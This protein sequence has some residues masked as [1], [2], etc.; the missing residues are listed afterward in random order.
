MK[1][2]LASVIFIFLVVLSFSCKKENT[3]VPVRIYLTDNPTAYDEVNV[4]IVGVQVKTS[5]DTTKWYS[6]QANVAVYNLL[7][8]QN[9]VTAV[10]AQGDVPQSVLK[11]IRFILGT[12][13]TVK[14]NGQTYPLQTPS[15]EDSGLK[16]KIDKHLQETLNTFTLDFD[17]ELSIK[18]EGNGIYK[19]EPTIKYKL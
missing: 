14:V 13:N 6:L 7:T 16:I 17:A 11:E 1:K 12:N 10:L 9:G 18:D 4:E 2:K 15:A 19:L 8:L 5:K 3:S